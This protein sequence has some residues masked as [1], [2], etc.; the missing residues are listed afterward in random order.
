[1]L[2]TWAWR[3]PSALQAVFSILTIVILPFVP[4]SPRWLA[5]QGR[6][7]EALEVI[8]LTHA[9]GDRTDPLV[10][11]AYSEIIDTLTWEK[12]SGETLSF[13]QT[14]R[15]K[16]SRKRL[17]LSTSVAVISMLSGN[18]IITYYLGGMLTQAGI[19]NTTTQLEIVS[20]CLI[21]RIYNF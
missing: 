15:T 6:N 4:E 20:H 14:V 2:S 16:S 1:M 11:V 5:Y 12:E 13:A 17:L 10:T 19:T 8:A 21:L 18:N 7:A 3:L 9:N